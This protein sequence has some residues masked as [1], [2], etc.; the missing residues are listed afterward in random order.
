M[1]PAEQPLCWVITGPEEAFSNE[2]SRTLRFN[3]LDAA[4]SLIEFGTLHNVDDV[5][6][7]DG[8]HDQ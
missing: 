7:Q 6:I 5:R 1:I 2:R 4:K 3:G 8:V